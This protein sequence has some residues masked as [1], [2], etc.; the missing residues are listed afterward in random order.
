M[1][2]LQRTWLWHVAAA[3]LFVV[4]TSLHGDIVTGTTSRVEIVNSG[5]EDTFTP[6][7]R[8]WLA[9]A[10]GWQKSIAEDACVLVDD[11]HSGKV[12]ARLREGTLSLDLK[13]VD[14][15]GKSL[16]VGFYAKGAG[17][18]SCSIA[19][20]YKE[21]DK[22]RRGG[23]RSDIGRGAPL[24][25]QY[26]PYRVNFSPV[27][28]DVAYVMLT[29][30]G[31]ATIDDICLV[32][33]DTPFD[34]D[35]KK[36]FLKE[37]EAMPEAYS[38]GVNAI[39]TGLVNVASFAGI[40][41]KPF[42]LT[43]YRAVD[44][45]MGTGVSFEAFPIDGA[46]VFDFIYDQA[47]DVCGV[48]MSLP[49]SDFAIYADIDGSGK[50]VKELVTVNGGSTLSYWGRKAWPWYSLQLASPVKARAIRYII[51]STSA[52]ALM[53]FQILAPSSQAGGLARPPAALAN[54]PLLTKGE[55]MTLPVPAPEQ[56]YLQGFTI[57]PWM[58]G[59]QGGY[60]PDKPR[61]PLADWAEF[62]SMM[63]D[64]KYFGAN[65]IN[66]FPPKTCVNVKGRKGTFA[67]DVMWPSQVWRWQSKEN[68][69]KELMETVKAESDIKVFTTIRYPYYRQ[70]LPPPSVAETETYG[71]YG[72]N[73]IQSSREMAEAG[74]DGLSVILDEQ[75]FG[76]GYPIFYFQK[77]SVPD[78]ASPSDRAAIVLANQVAEIRRQAFRRRWGLSL[79][80]DEFPVRPKDNLLYRQY[81]IFYYEQQAHLMRDIVTAARAAN[82]AV[83]S[84]T[85]FSTTDHFNNRL[86]RASDHDIFGF[87]A[88]IDIMAG[89]PYFTLEDP[90]GCYNPSYM[91]Q[92]WRASG[93]KRIAGLTLN[94]SWGG[95]HPDRNPLCAQ[96]YPPIC[97]VGAVLGG[98]LNGAREFN[99]WRYNFACGMD[100]IEG[101]R[102][103]VKKAFEMLDT[104][105]A[106]GGKSGRT[107]AD[108]AVLRSRASEDWWQLRQQF[109]GVSGSSEDCSNGVSYFK[110]VASH[111][112]RN[113]RCFE[114]FFADH[115]ESFQDIGR[116]RTIILPFAYSMDEKCLAIIKKAIAGG[117]N[118]IVLG[119]SGETD[120]M[121]QP[122][123]HPLL[124]SLIA[125]QKVRRF[126]ADVITD[127]HLPGVES[128]FATMLDASLGDRNSLTLERHGSDIQ[129]GLLET[130]V[131]EKL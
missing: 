124:L 38:A 71:L 89:D 67:W 21:G 48:R 10:N 5:F 93:P 1:A 13:E 131:A 58:Y 29:F 88:D 40:R 31:N 4:T 7:N 125:E 103:G 51:F 118:V 12:A 44:G 129:V 37:G 11:A 2:I 27:E 47:I 17:C 127:G 130:G 41:T 74:V 46:K 119:G 26:L 112:L 6:V 121:G 101:G 56:K 110:W 73:R 106:W 104:L 114:T 109:G 16:S 61:R 99:F 22:W 53:E 34:L 97:Y 107:P 83:K 84:Y 117:S 14:L 95:G 78:D 100:P 108:I 116:F 113:G 32:A 39:P 81:V 59:S 8:G 128:A 86:E 45:I 36:V 123:P 33:S 115:P 111:L 75:M 92:V 24:S 70:D 43:P 49:S 69:L 91:S 52:S 3:V 60:N 76:A 20:F 50:Y 126:D 120:A 25:E 54:L 94:Y 98:A 9:A 82:P 57:E 55:K 23:L 62:R 30:I 35:Q 122:Y 28:N 105:A 63:D 66:L 64:F 15:R 19:C 77:K 72:R 68:Y 90:W 79:S 80:D 18:L 87:A 65:F 42:A 85:A 102:E 96:T